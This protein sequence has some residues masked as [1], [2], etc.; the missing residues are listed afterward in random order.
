[1]SGLLAWGIPHLAPAW[2]F[3]LAVTV[4]GLW[5]MFENTDFVIHRY[6]TATIA[7]GYQGDT[8]INSMGDLLCC[9]VGFTLAQR[10]GFRRS[11]LL[12]MVTEVAL[13]IAIRD[14][15]LLNL[16]MLVYPIEGIHAWQ[17]GR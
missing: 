1:L 17:V 3:W 7:L 16:V 15:L 13:L 4:E 8:I 5:E 12:C 2:R 9:A 14:S 11:F 6:R 10:L